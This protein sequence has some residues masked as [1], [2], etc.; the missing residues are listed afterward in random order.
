MRQ[1]DLPRRWYQLKQEV[2]PARLVEEQAGASVNVFITFTR[3][4]SGKLVRYIENA[5]TQTQIRAAN[6][7][8]DNFLEQVKLEAT[9]LQKIVVEAVDRRQAAEWQRDTVGAPNSLLQPK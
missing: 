9:T 7:V 2:K 3:Q 4:K 5:R 6:S 8:F 1:N